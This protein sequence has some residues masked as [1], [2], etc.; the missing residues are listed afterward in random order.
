MTVPFRFRVRSLLLVP[1]V[2]AP[3]GGCSA[4]DRAL[5]VSQSQPAAFFQ[6]DG[7]AQGSAFIVSPT[8]LFYHTVAGP[9][10]T[11]STNGIPNDSCSVTPQDDGFFPDET[12]ALIA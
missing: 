6:L 11:Y 5:A 8:A 12:N 9:A 10:K 7:K 2:V 1:A 4:L 3:A